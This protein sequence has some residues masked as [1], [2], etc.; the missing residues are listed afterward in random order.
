MDGKI[1]YL[2]GKER[3]VLAMYKL[4][5]HTLLAC[6]TFSLASL[7]CLGHRSAT[8]AHRV[9]MYGDFLYRFS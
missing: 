2:Q 8:L 6:R 5:Y 3:L 4:S 1:A 9:S 7:H